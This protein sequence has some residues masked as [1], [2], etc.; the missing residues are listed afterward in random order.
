MIKPGKDLQISSEY[1]CDPHVLYDN[2]KKFYKKYNVPDWPP[3]KNSFIKFLTGDIR[4]VLGFYRNQLID[5]IKLSH[6][7]Q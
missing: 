7:Y 5:W 4:N 2:F 3:T 1:H 6:N